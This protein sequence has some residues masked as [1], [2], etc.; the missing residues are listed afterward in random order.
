FRSNVDKLTESD[1][2]L[3]HFLAQISK[4]GPFQI[5]FH[6]WSPHYRISIFN[7]RMITHDLNAL[8]Y[9]FLMQSFLTEIT[10]YAHRVG[11][12]LLSRDLSE[13]AINSDKK[14]NEELLKLNKS[15]EEILRERDLRKEWG[16]TPAQEDL[17]DK[18]LYASF[19]LRDCLAL[20]FIS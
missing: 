11:F 5:G 15:L 19:L 6:S 18:Y 17:L 8:A 4:E 20:A 9:P 14:S 10:E 1:Q 2:A 16:L 12:N 13:L 7:K 3:T